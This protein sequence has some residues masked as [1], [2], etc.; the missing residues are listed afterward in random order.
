MNFTKVKRVLFPDSS[1]AVYKCDFAF[2]L[3]HRYLNQT[4]DQFNTK[5]KVKTLKGF[6][7]CNI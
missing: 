5:D 1:Q 4:D 3:I 2:R 7:A 6:C